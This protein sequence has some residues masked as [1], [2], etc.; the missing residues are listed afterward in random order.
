M[1]HSLAS[2]INNQNIAALFNRGPVTKEIISC[3]LFAD[4]SLRGWRRD[5]MLRSLENGGL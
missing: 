5:T 4:I 2:F 3:E 1:E